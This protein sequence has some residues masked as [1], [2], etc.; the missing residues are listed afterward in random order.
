M[1]ARTVNRVILTPP[2]ATKSPFHFNFKEAACCKP[3]KVIYD[4]FLLFSVSK[5][6]GGR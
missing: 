4:G 3:H 6:E 2:Q 5:P 1:R